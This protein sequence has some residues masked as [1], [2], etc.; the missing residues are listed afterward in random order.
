MASAHDITALP[1]SQEMAGQRMPRRFLT[2]ALR[3]S[4]QR[5][6][7]GDEP[8]GGLELG[9]GA[10]TCLAERGERFAHALVVEV[11]GYVHVAAAGIDPFSDP[12]C[13]LGT[14][15]GR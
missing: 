13:D 10:A 11:D 2:I 8:A 5:S 7:V 12:A 9:C 15:P 3:S 6:A 14:R 4:P 1:C